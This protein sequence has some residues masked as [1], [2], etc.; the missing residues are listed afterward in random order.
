MSRYVKFMCHSTRRAFTLVE[1]LVVIAIIGILVAL[2]LPAIQAARES[3]RRS[4]CLNNLKQLGLALHNHADSLKVFPSGCDT[5]IAKGTSIKTAGN[6]GGSSIGG[7]WIY[8]LLPYIEETGIYNKLNNKVTNPVADATNLA[9][10]AE[11]GFLNVSRCPSDA[12]PEKVTRPDATNYV[13]NMGTTDSAVHQK[14]QQ[15]IRNDCIASTASSPTN[16]P[17]Y[18]EGKRKMRE[19][20]DGLSKTLSLSECTIGT[21]YA[22]ANYGSSK[23]GPCKKG[24]DG[25][26][27]M[28]DGAGA[29]AG[30]VRGESWFASPGLQHWSFSG[31]LLP[32]DIATADHD[33]YYLLHYGAYAARSR[34]PG[35]VHVVM[36]DGSVAPCD[37]L[38]TI[39]VWRGFSTINRGEITEVLD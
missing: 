12:A 2:L 22:T 13:A 20:A 7:G 32:N 17:F 30:N 8:Q 36:N 6:C 27:T 35:I 11:N 31:Q 38:V 3:A 34:H 16:G 24:T 26:V 39:N 19:F 33:C 14:Y 29:I 25:I 37:D 1:L 10:L 9:I 18:C 23:Y 5:R 15:P 21:P 28:P 4:Q